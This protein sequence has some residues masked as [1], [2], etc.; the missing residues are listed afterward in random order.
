GTLI[1]TNSGT[2]WVDRFSATNDTNSLITFS[3]GTLNSGNSA[4]SNGTL[5]TVGD[6]VSVATLR[7]NGGTH[8]FANSLFI[9][10]NA[11]LT[12]TGAITGAITNAGTVAPGDSAG[13]LAGSSD[14]TL[15]SNS[16]LWMEV[17]GTNAWLYD[18][19][20][21]AGTLTFAG[22][23]GVSLTNGFAPQWGDRFDL[24][25]FSGSGGSFGATNLPALQPGWTWNTSLLY[26]S[27]EIFPQDIG[28][29]TNIIN[30][31]TTNHPGIYYVGAN[32]A[33]NGLIITNGGVLTSAGG[34]IG[35]TA[36]A[37]NNNAWV[38]GVGSLWSNSG[39]LLVGATGAFNNLMIN[40]GGTVLA[41]NIVV[42]FDPNST[43]N[44]IVVS[45]GNLWAT[46][47]AG[48]GALDVRRG[49]LTINSGTVTV[50]RL[51]ATNGA[52]SVVN[53]NGGTLNSGGSTVS[54][55]SVFSVGNG[56]SNATL[57]LN[58]G[59]HSFANGLFIN[60]NGW[61]R[62]TGV[63]S[64]D[65]TNAGTIAPGD[66][67]G[68]IAGNDDLTLLEASVLMMELAG[69]DPAVY[70]QLNLA[71][72]LNFDGTLNVSLLGGFNPVAGNV[73]D[74]F[75]FSASAGVFD[76]T[77]LPALGQWLYWDTSLLYTNGEISVGS[78]G[79]KIISPTNGSVMTSS[80]MLIT[81]TAQAAASEYGLW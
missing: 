73:F 69:T 63:I 80:S 3:G 59:A 9:N 31:Y 16:V 34:V 74:L 28:G 39:S 12:G 20:N 1:L 11:T 65:I 8:S 58:G 50:N 54:N 30:G 18:Q 79:A 17:A 23:L 21:L 5:F 33:F 77:N 51:Y 76:Q 71:G 61:L 6:G 25:D 48:G 53:F 41:T 44:S 78:L 4:V 46:N 57:R 64:G 56:L 66:S 68:V 45:G 55:G 72:M 29:W 60:T 2:I 35:N 38:T 62:G 13:I 7:L 10:T 32:S 19:I 70:D 26:T 15:L 24:F 75:D 67:A 43:G 27:G 47:G 49:A 40:N 52:L 22:T 14:L 36:L 37:S 81:W 42:G